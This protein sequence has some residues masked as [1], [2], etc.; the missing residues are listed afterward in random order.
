MAKAIATPNKPSNEPSR[1]PSPAPCPFLESTMQPSA[2]HASSAMTA[3]AIAASGTRAP[4]RRRDTLSPN[5]GE[6]APLARKG[7]RGQRVPSQTN[8]RGR[9]PL[10][11]DA[12]LS[13]PILGRQSDALIGPRNAR[14]TRLLRARG[15]LF[16]PVSSIRTATDG[17]W[18][19]AVSHPTDVAPAQLPPEVSTRHGQHS[20]LVRGLTAGDLPDIKCASC[21]DYLILDLRRGHM[22]LCAWFTAHANAPA[23][24]AAEISKIQQSPQ[25]I[26][27]Q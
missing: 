24:R 17:T 12:Q 8:G 15:P 7:T 14:H 2:P 16:R 20:K 26:R 10:F 19:P 23:L 25:L 5:K 13:L 1:N 6:S 9:P 21:H 18:C 3:T 22:Q 27:L 4:F 11:G